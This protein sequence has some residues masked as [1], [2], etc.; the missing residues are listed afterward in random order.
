VEIPLGAAWG[1]GLVLFRT[2][3]LLL[4]APILAARVVAPRIRLA[5]GLA[6]AVAVWSGAGALSAPVPSPWAMVAG[7]ACETALGA[8]AGFAARMALEAALAAGQLMSLSAG[9]GFGALIDPSSG[10]ESNAASQLLFV[11]AQGA[12]IALGVHRQ[13]VAWLARSAAAFPPGG[14]SGL[15]ELAARAIWEAT[16]AAALAVRLAFPVLAAVMVGHLVL[17]V[18]G[19]TAPQLG[20]A[21]VGYALGILAGGGA[22]YLLAPQAAELAARAALAALS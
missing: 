15:Q 12:A 10:S 2:L 18:L 6:V 19:R 11:T 8:L 14:P 17:G 22:F 9:I 1:F 7:A 13:A 3:G 20:L 21:S 5:V 16:G 4:T